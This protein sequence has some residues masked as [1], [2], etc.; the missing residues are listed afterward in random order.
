[1]QRSQKSMIWNS[2]EGQNSF[3]VFEKI[4]KLEGLFSTETQ[5]GL[6]CLLHPKPGRST[7]ILGSS[8]Q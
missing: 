3:L 7:A 8:R 5:P 2:V 6:A 4:L 1:M